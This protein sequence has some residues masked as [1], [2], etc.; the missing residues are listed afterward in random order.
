MPR[1]HMGNIKIGTSKSAWV[2]FP[3]KGING[4]V[5]GFDALDRFVD[6][7]IFLCEAHH[8]CQLL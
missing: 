7:N 6:A 2:G 3:C 4:L 8:H 5:E 1:Q